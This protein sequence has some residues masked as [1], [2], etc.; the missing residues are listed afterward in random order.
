MSRDQGPTD[1]E[2]PFAWIDDC[3]TYVRRWLLVA[4]GFFAVLAMAAFSIGFFTVYF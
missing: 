2:L 3:I 1:H 4:A